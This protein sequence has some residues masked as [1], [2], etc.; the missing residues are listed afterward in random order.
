MHFQPNICGFTSKR[1]ALRVHIATWSDFTL[2]AL[3]T[4]LYAILTHGKITTVLLWWRCIRSTH[5]GIRITQYA[6][7]ESWL[8][9]FRVIT[10]MHIKLHMWFNFDFSLNHVSPEI[11]WDVWFRKWARMRGA[12]TRSRR[13]K[14]K[15]TAELSIWLDSSNKMLQTWRS[16]CHSTKNIT[17][18]SWNIFV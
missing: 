16:H 15:V 6:H 7:I 12:K 8:N 4:T 11:L 1:S 2:Y 3:R 18:S 14:C 5:Y 9:L 17:P 10:G 13:L